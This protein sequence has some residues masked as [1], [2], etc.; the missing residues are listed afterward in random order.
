MD[1]LIITAACDCLNSWPS[2]PYMPARGYSET[3][4]SQYVSAFEAG[5]SVLHHHGSVERDSDSGRPRV[6]FAGWAQMTEALRARA[7]GALVHYG[8]AGMLPADKRRLMVEQRPELMSTPTEPH[9]THFAPDPSGHRLDIYT[10][11]PREWLV[12]VA[13]DSVELG[14]RIESE[15]FTTGSCWT[16]GFLIEQGLLPA[17]RWATIFLGWP[18]G[19]WTPPTPDSLHYM[20]RSL[21]PETSWNLSVMDPESSWGLIALAIELGGHV[22][23]GWEDNPYLPNG[24]TARDNA[25]LVEVAV[26]IA[27]SLG[28][29]IAS[30][31][32]ARE[33][34]GVTPAAGS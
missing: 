21:P 28:R 16:M 13:R 29:E 12:E 32:R 34:I 1:E 9:D 25:Q 11:Y 4:V 10:T 3:L 26:G 2:N 18:G 17:P 24:A 30:P 8:I 31:A 33:I 6:D 23:V 27:R 19:T 15:C 7:D 22:R 5:A 14:T 20:I